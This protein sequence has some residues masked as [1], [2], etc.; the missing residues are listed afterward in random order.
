M[1]IIIK[2]AIE[3]IKTNKLRVIVAMVWIILG[4]TSVVVVSG[5]G[6]GIEQKSKEATNNPDFRK[7]SIKFY[8]NYEKLDNVNLF[9]PFT[10]EDV[11]KISLMDGVERV[12]PKYGEATSDLAY[13]GQ[14]SSEYG[15]LFNEFEVYKDSNKLD[16]KYGRTFSL[17]DLDRKTI[18]IE[19]FVAKELFDNI[20][21][22]AI[23]KPVDI[24]GEKYEV[25]GVLDG[26][27]VDS[28]DENDESE[29]FHQPKAYLP[30]RIL[31][32]MSNQKNYGGVIRGLELLISPGHDVVDVAW[33]IKTSLDDIK[34]EDDGTYEVGGGNEAG[35]ELE[36]LKF[37]IN[38]FTSILSTVS[39]LIG[40][41]GIMNIMYMSVAERK[42][43]IGIRRAIGA[44]PKDILVQF[45]IET[46][47]ITILG[48]IVG[49]IVGTLA[50]TQVSTYLGGI[51]AIPSV[52]IYI[53]AVA[54]SV[55]VGAVFGAI[56]AMKA[57]KLDPINAIQG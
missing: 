46:I 13:G 55:L 19:N 8:P 24:N 48:G 54:V 1:M 37:T 33:K 22:N 35:G 5:I 11:D 21:K 57:A 28:K 10:P 43:E 6:N 51:D 25:I 20:P 44:E 15:D 30:K 47:V 26:K 16:I 53:K 23:G 2:N 39:L 9:E 12:T 7:I 56:P 49:M 18:V 31:E 36:Y 50:S 32:E 41:I 17:E 42:R 45:L 38:R 34:S 40:G 3:N 29:Q 52:P 14:I 27:E 4:I